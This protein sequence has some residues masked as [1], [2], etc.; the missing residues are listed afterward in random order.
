MQ[1]ALGLLTG[2]LANAAL[3]RLLARML[4][5]FVR[6]V[7]GKSAAT[8]RV[9]LDS[10][11]LVL[12]N[13][14]FNLDALSPPE[15][16][17]SVKRAFAAELRIVIP[18]A[19]LATEPLQVALTGVD[20]VVWKSLVGD[21]LGEQ[22]TQQQVDDKEEEEDGAVLLLGAV[23]SVDV[24]ITNMVV[25]LQHDSLAGVLCLTCSSAAAH[26]APSLAEAEKVR[27]VQ[28]AGHLACACDSPCRP[29]QSWSGCASQLRSRT[30]GLQR[31]MMMSRSLSR[32]FTLQR[33]ACRLCFRCFPW[34][35]VSCLLIGFFC[36]RF[37]IV[38][39]LVCFGVSFL[40]L[41]VWVRF[42]LCLLCLD[43]LAQNQK[44]HFL[45]DWRL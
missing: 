40:G 41:F 34:C 11:A 42:F 24:R 10:N 29:Q 13:V 22:K 21:D 38:L 23:N 12:K 43:S 15:A 44:Y 7:D 27:R 2:R 35:F 16:P 26:N 6:S 17:L 37:L 36:F 9:A 1:R 25:R 39:P 28:A 45:P 32:C 33:P 4:R 30:C 31:S 19:T 8:L 18:W 3:A 14:E 20:V 5:R